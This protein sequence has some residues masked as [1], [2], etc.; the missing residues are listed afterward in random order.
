MFA[1]IQAILAAVVIANLVG[2]LRQFSRLRDLW[3]IHKPDAVNSS[4]L[5]LFNPLL[6]NISIRILLTVL[7]TFLK[8]LTERIYLTIKSFFNWLSFPV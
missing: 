2:L 3:G 8:V 1:L 6:P 7:Y 4:L 5:I